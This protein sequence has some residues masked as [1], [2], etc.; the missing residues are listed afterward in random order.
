VSLRSGGA[1]RSV[2]AVGMYASTV[3]GIVGSIVVLRVLRPEGAG[4][5]SIAVGTAAFFQLLLELTSDEALIKFGFRYAE[6]EDW[7]RFQRLVRLMCG[8][9][10]FASLAAGALVAL[11]GLLSPTIFHA[12]LL[13]PM[14]FA[15]L[16]PPL[17]AIES[18]AAAALV[19]RRRYDVRALFLTFSMSLRLLAIVIGSHYGVTATV[20]GI[21]LAQVVT[22]ASIAAVGVK[23]LRRF[24]LAKP[25]SLGDDRRPLLSF[26][27]QSTAGTTL[28]SLRTWAAPLLLGVVR[29][30]TD[31]G[32]FRGAQAPLQ[33]SAA[34]TAPLRLILL[35]EQTR[36]WERG[37]TE[38]VY[39]EI[40]RYMVGAAVLTAVVIVPLELAMPWLVKLFLGSPYAPATDAVRIVLVAA[41]IQLVLGWT[42]S[43]P[44]SIGRPGLRVV[45]HGIET[46]TLL[47]LVIVF[48]NEWG[49][50]G[51]AVAVLVSTCVFA[52]VWAVLLRRLTVGRLRPVEAT[53]A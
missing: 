25:S 48:G 40:R 33:G 28:V 51:A 24:P 52:V 7:G 36:S 10:F 35:T 27:L 32:L 45:A 15:A 31:V 18:M 21:V 47:P 2:T 49:V 29:N 13:E 50:T 30:P 26:V 46:A 22:T 5:F 1:R 42:K 9:E 20:V 23:A 3:L 43:F 53:P 8:F 44:V 34:F 41:M 6:H 4:R 11:A 39:R 37:E 38:K 16:L 19:L 12:H 17:Q 14:L